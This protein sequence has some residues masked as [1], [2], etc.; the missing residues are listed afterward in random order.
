MPRPNQAHSRRLRIGQGSSRL[1]RARKLQPN[2]A[3]FPPKPRAESFVARWGV[4]G[5]FIARFSGPLRASVPLAAGIFEMPFW[6][7]QLANFGSAMVW[8]ATLLTL[9]DAVAWLIHLI[10]R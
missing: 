6:R 3:T 5:I 9:G 7:F 8:A 1:V 2:R 4:P 10:W